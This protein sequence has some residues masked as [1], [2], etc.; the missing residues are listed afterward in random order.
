MPIEPIYEDEDH[1]LKQTR[2]KTNPQSKTLSSTQE[3]PYSPDEFDIDTPKD[4]DNENRL[5]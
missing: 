1:D 3:N 4:I 5:F 2:M